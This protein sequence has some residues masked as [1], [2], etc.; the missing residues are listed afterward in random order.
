MAILLHAVLNSSGRLWSTLPE[1][2]VEPPSAAE[3]AQT[4]HIDLMMTIV[5]WVAAVIVVLVYGP[6]DLSRR[7]RH[8]LVAFG[9]GETQPRVR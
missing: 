9:N 6:R 3:A 1:Y 4:V 8:V 7:P 5:L 2:S